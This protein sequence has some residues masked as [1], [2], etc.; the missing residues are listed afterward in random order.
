ML[1][2]RICS[3]WRTV[4]YNTPRL[5]NTIHFYTEFPLTDRL[6]PYVSSLAE[7]SRNLPLFVEIDSSSPLPNS[8]SLPAGTLTN[9]TYILGHR[10]QKLTLKLDDEQSGFPAVFAADT[11]FP[12]LQSLIVIVYSDLN[13]VSTNLG[14]ILD[15][16]TE[17]PSL[18]HL[19]VDAMAFTPNRS[20]SFPWA[21]LTSLDLTVV[22]DIFDARNILAH[23][24]QV[25]KCKISC[26]QPADEE[27]TDLP[28]CVLGA[29]S[30]LEFGAWDE[31]IITSPF[32][33][34]FSFP[35][36]ESL[37]IYAYDSARNLLFDLHARSGFNLKQLHLSNISLDVDALIAFL[38]IVPALTVLS[39]K[40]S[41]YV[42]NGLFEAFTFHS[43][44]ESTEITL[45]LLTTLTLQYFA[46]GLDGKTIARMVESLS[47]RMLGPLPSPRS[48]ASGLGCPACD[49]AKTLRHRIFGRLP[50]ETHCKQRSLTEQF[51]VSRWRTTLIAFSSMEKLSYA[52]WE[53]RR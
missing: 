33:Q 4:A 9:A 26:L 41:D 37:T 52:Q 7:R 38:R 32:F 40:S 13:I 46:D 14:A 27:E 21:Q 50:D 51:R 6:T 5:W 48:N 12:I 17:A 42:A 24:S 2:G 10:L 18:R 45:P 43:S 39:L 23:C 44:T 49:S 53:L 28:M 36:L 22:F 19:T 11:A 29:L 47:P 15:L 25:T 30:S 16:F 3:L 1:L 31:D 34:P 35:N 20:T 8:L